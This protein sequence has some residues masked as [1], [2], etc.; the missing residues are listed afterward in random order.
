VPVS[1]AVGVVPVEGRGALPFQLYGGE[2]LVALASWALTEAEVELLDLTA[3]WADVQARGCALVIHDPL[4]PAT[5][6]PFLRSVVERAGTDPAVLVG[7]RPVTDTVRRVADGVL[8]E[9]VDRRGLVGVA[10]PVVL[11]AAVVADLT[12]WPDLTDLAPLV[13]GLAERFRVDLVDAPPLARRLADASDL[14]LLE[15]L[16]GPPA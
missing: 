5:P 3:S 13:E 14:V 2:S 6:V 9:T 12:E 7:V 11:P 15:G 8:A 10:S 4:C 1:A 16:A